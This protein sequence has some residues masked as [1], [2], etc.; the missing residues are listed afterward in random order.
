MTSRGA[1]PLAAVGAA[2]ALAFLA[3]D[4]GRRTPDR[5]A[6]R[7]LTL[8]ADRN[9]VQDSKDL[10]TAA[11]AAGDFARAAA[12]IGEITDQPLA[13]RL[14][15][16]IVDAWARTN[17]AEA[18][19]WA[20]NLPDCEQKGQIL[21]H[22]GVIW[23]ARNG[24]DA[25]HFAAQLVSGPAREQMLT[26]VFHYWCSRDLIAASEWLGRFDHANECDAPLAVVAT[27]PRL[28]FEFPRTALHFAES[29]AAPAARLG[30]IRAIV[31]QWSRHDNGAAR[32]YVYLAAALTPAQRHEL[33]ATLDRLPRESP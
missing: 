20:V 22:V 1:L 12:F 8:S 4:T 32:D 25:A 10:T 5:A 23:A 7:D 13:L 9:Q 29:I 2:I 27:H 24:A 19:A 26:N 14:A 21:S 33:I 15:A 28:V 31:E 11:I 16:Q 30:T 6:A 18:A 17:P 3:R